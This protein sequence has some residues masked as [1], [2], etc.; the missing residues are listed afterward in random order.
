[1]THKHDDLPPDVKDKGELTREELSESLDECWS[2]TPRS[3]TPNSILNHKRKIDEQAYQ[4]IKKLIESYDPDTAMWMDRCH[5]LEVKLAQKPK[6]SREEV[7]HFHQNLMTIAL[8]IGLIENMEEMLKTSELAKVER[9]Y[10]TNWLKSK[11]VIV[12]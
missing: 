6:V 10:I 2:L 8:D 11:G 12:E 5:E 1:M 9:E 3:E 4:Q 7:F